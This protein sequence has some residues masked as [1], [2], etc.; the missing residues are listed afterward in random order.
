MELKNIK[1][2]LRTLLYNFYF[3]DFTLAKQACII[4]NI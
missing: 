3:V 4:L 1:I 2:I